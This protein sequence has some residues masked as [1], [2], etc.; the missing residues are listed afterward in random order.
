MLAPEELRQEI[1]EDMIEAR[2]FMNQDPS[3]HGDRRG[4]RPV[5]RAP[6]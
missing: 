2:G 4:D 1:A 5:A 6:V 3:E